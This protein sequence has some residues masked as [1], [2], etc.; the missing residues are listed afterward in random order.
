MFK[1][2]LENPV[3]QAWA[4]ESCDSGCLRAHM[5]STEFSESLGVCEHTP[6]MELTVTLSV[7]STHLLNEVFLDVFEHT[8]PQWNFLGR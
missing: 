5:S 4:A 2:I 8:P 1:N 3:T 6:S 7:L